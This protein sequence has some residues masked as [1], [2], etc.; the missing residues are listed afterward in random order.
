M[1]HP[2]LFPLCAS[3]RFIG[4]IG[5]IAGAVVAGVLMRIFG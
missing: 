1:D 3:C 2:W 5:L 4:K